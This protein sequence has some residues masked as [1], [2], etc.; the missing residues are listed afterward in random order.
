MSPSLSSTLYIGRPKPC[1]AQTTL[2]H[3]GKV[4]A[5][6]TQPPAPFPGSLLPCLTLLT[7]RKFS[8]MSKAVG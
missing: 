2:T 8:L 6:I 5:E 4:P 3:P 7:I 1:R